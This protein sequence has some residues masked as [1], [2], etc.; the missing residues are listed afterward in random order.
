MSGLFYDAVAD[1][2]KPSIE[3]KDKKGE[4]VDFGLV[5][6]FN[7][8]AVYFGVWPRARARRRHH[9]SAGMTDLSGVHCGLSCSFISISI[10]V[11]KSTSTARPP[12]LTTTGMLMLR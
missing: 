11:N 12:P 5:L 8:T 1:K 3:I 9:P 6:T 2:V 7:F 4:T 10:S